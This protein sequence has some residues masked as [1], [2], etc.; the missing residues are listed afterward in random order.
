MGIRAADVVFVAMRFTE[1]KELVWLKMNPEQKAYWIRQAHNDLVL[2]QKFI[3]ETQLNTE[4]S[5]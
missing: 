3:D 1:Q 2:A 4:S 5:T